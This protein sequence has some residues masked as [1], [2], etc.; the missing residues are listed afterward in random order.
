MDGRTAGPRVPAWRVLPARALEAVAGARC[1]SLD[2]TATPDPVAPDPAAVAQLVRGL[3]VLV[4]AVG[5]PGAGPLP[6]DPHCALAVVADL[7]ATL[8]DAARHVAWTAGVAGQD[9]AAAV[10]DAVMTTAWALRV[11]AELGL[12]VVPAPDG[13]EPAPPRDPAP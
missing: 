3:E 13:G 2:R 12:R 5:T 8:T 7:T 10:A 1:A 4:T 6:V 11:L 9:Q